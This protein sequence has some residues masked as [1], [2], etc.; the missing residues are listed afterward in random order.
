MPSKNY[1]I[2]LSH[3]VSQDYHMHFE[4]DMTSLSK[5]ISHDKQKKFGISLN[6]S[7]Q[8]ALTTALIGE[9]F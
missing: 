4:L 5:L 9:P 3:R 2:D 8:N 6:R 1:S 7:H